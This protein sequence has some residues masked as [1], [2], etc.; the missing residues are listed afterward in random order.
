[1]KYSTRGTNR[2]AIWVFVMNETKVYLA[3]DIQ[4][5]QLDHIRAQTDRIVGAKGNDDQMS[6][7]DQILKE[8]REDAERKTS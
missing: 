3:T 8:I 2:Q 1:M 5:A 6:K 7:V 4:K